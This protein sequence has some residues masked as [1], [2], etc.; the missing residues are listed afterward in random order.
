MTHAKH[1]A[2]KPPRLRGAGAGA[3]GRLRE[4]PRAICASPAPATRSALPSR[5]SAARSRRSKSGSACRFSRLHRA[6]G[7]PTTARSSTQRRSRRW[8]ELDRATRERRGQGRAKAAVVVTTTPGFAGVWLIPRLAGFTA[9][10]PGVDVRISAEQEPVNLDRDGVDVARPPSAA[11]IAGR[12]G[13]DCSARRVF[14][15]CSPAPAARAAPLLKPDDLAG[16]HAARDGARRQKSAA[17]LGPLAEAHALAD[18]GRRGAALLWLRPADS[19][20]GCRPRRRA[21]PRAADRQPDEGEELVAPFADAVVSPQGYCMVVSTA[22]ARR[23]RSRPSPRGWRRTARAPGS[24][25]PRDR[26]RC[27]IARISLQRDR[28]LALRQLVALER[29][30]AVLG[31]DRAAAARHG[32]VDERLTA[33]SWRRRNSA[34]SSPSGRLHVVVQVAVAQV[35]EVH[36]PRRREGARCS[37]ASVR[38]DEVGDRRHRQRDVVLDVRAFLGLRQRDRLAQVP[39]RV[40]LR[41]GCSATAASSIRPRSSAASSSASKRARAVR[42]AL[43]VG[44]L[45]QHRPRPP[46]AAAARSCGKCLRTSSSAKRAHHLEAGERRRRGA[47]ARARAARRAASSVGSAASAVQ[48]RRGQRI[49]LQRRRGDDAERAFAADRTGRA[50]RSRCCPCAG[51]VRP[52]QTSPCGGHDLEPQAQLARIAVAQ[53]LRAA[54]IG[55]EVAA[56]RA[57]AFGRQAEREQQALRR[58]RPPAPRCSTQPASTRHRQVGARRW[59][60]RGSCA[61]GSAAPGVPLSSG[62]EPPTSPVL[63]PCGDDGR[64]VRGAGAHH[65]CDFGGRCR[66]APRPAPCRGSACASRPRRPTRSPSVEHVGGADGG[67]QARR[68]ARRS[69]SPPSARGAAPRAGAQRTCAARRRRTAAGTAAPRRRRAGADSRGRW[70][71][72][73]RLRRS[74][75][76]PAG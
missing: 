56:D 8:G 13:S 38:G 39:Q 24:A 17:G 50:G 49:Q 71:R 48:P 74:R 35:A 11:S 3:P 52:S 59:R 44:L 57:A 20:G 16:P 75:A 22:A 1:A 45:Q 25:R 34:A 6:L 65:R 43:A 64:A 18:L 4:R 63:P 14:P 46:A 5:R 72:A 54:G 66:A 33:A 32:V 55:G 7:S 76:R 29:A 58:P 26:A 36:Q 51:P 47:A 15:V 68:A 70:S 53:H 61:S 41:R 30:D 42:L 23:P 21:R 10:H 67:A 73:P 62:I 40:R 19:G 27:L 60:A 37:A 12:R 69:S 31:R 2:C 9:A 28:R